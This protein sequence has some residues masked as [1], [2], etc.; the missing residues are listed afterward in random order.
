MPAKCFKPIPKVKSCLIQLTLKSQQPSIPFEKV[1]EFLE[2]FAPFS[3]KTLGAISKMIDKRFADKSSSSTHD[4]MIKFI[5]P[6]HLQKKRLEELGWDQIE[7]IL[8]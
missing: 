8:A 5:I 4:K 6:E 1:V 2:L 3:R 7:E